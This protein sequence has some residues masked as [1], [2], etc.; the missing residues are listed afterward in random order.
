MKFDKHITSTRT[1]F[2]LYHSILNILFFFI[3]T[4]LFS[5]GLR[6]RKPQAA[7][8]RVSPSC[9]AQTDDGPYLQ[10]IGTCPTDTR[11]GVS[12]LNFPQKSPVSTRILFCF[13]DCEF[14]IVPQALILCCR[15]LASNN[16]SG[17]PRVMSLAA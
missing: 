15:M 17:V 9:R 11:D 1:W 10:Y 3:S 7:A 12:N 4:R 8:S 13:H 6:K 16:E 14:I 5:F 2:I